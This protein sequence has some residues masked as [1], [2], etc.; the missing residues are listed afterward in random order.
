MVA[1]K[2]LYASCPQAIS[3]L[4]TVTE[5]IAGVF[6]PR[7]GERSLR[8]RGGIRGSWNQ[9]VE[10]NDLVMAFETKSAKDGQAKAKA[11]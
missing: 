5:D 4:N 9:T 3:S 6:H 2:C 11:F 1:Q 7:P 8:M 10:V